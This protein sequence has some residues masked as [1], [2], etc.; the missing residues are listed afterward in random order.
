MFL[1]GGTEWAV[2]VR[3]VRLRSRQSEQ[4]LVVA[5][6]SQVAVELMGEFND[7]SC[8][9]G[10]GVRELEFFVAEG[11]GVVKGDDAADSGN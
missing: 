3:R 1:G 11:N 5:I 6:N 4:E 2:S 10:A 9:A 7:G 8:V